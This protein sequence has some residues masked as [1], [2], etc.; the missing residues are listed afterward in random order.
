MRILYI[1]QKRGDAIGITDREQIH[2]LKKHDHPFIFL[3]IHEKGDSRV[4]IFFHYCRNF[5]L[6][7]IRSFPHKYLYF[8][9]ENPYIFLIKICY[10]HK[11]M[12]LCV[13]HLDAWADGFLG[14][15]ILHSAE[16]IIAISQYTKNQL[17]EKGIDEEKIFVNYNG[18]SQEFYPEKIPNFQ[19]F[20]YILYVGT[21]LQRKNF[22]KILEAFSV[23]HEKYP[24][25]KL[26][27]IGDAGGKI[28]E[29]NTDTIL[30]KYPK[31]TNSV[32]FIRQNISREELRKWYSNAVFYIS[33]SKL[34][35]F[36]MT[37]PEAEACGCPIIA[38]DIPVFREILKENHELVAP[39]NTINVV[40][41][42]E[43][44][45]KNPPKKIQKFRFSWE[46]NATNLISFFSVL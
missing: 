32:I 2:A 4:Q 14:K 27:K 12:Y 11:K 31:I 44:I 18:I 35:G 28:F 43:K 3:E 22:G 46:K 20:S 26:V 45:L 8:S 38:S 24:H 13:H 25:I 40:N 37:L 17:I 15:W 30:K 39:D 42:M 5:F 33:L 21:E 19:N 7:L 1:H 34:E 23:F 36:G 41:A 6:L 16:K 29:K 9:Y 10:P